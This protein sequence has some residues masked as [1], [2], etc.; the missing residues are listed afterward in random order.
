GGGNL[1]LY[2]D[3][4]VVASPSG[5]NQLVETIS[6]D[7]ITFSP[8]VNT[9]PS[10]DCTGTALHDCVTGNEGISGNQVVDPATGN[11]Y[12]AHTTTNGNSAGSAVGVRVSEGKITPGT[13]TTGTWTESPNLDAALC[14]DP[15]CVASS[16]NPEELAGENF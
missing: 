11:V 8:V 10:A 3:Y 13:P 5:G 2:Q 15:S 7:G 9:N 4:D 14:P 16:G 1:N 12:I 6:H